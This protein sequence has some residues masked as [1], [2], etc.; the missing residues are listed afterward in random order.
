MNSIPSRSRHELPAGLRNAALAAVLLSSVVGFQA[1]LEAASL[2]NLEALREARPTPGSAL[3][4]S[5]ELR[6][7]IS[8]AESAAQV[9]ALEP[10]ASSRAFV[11]AALSVACGL[12]FVSAG[13]L[14]RPAGLPR[15]GMRGLLGG[16]ALAAAVLRTI[17]G[18]QAALVARR[19]A[20]ALVE[21]LQKNGDFGQLASIERAPA[22]ISTV[23]LT[24]AVAPTALVAGAFV[25]LS[26]YFHSERVKQ[27][28]AF[29]DKQLN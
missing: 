18:A 11:L 15:N 24:V 9:S 29:G 16:S 28:V 20:S 3:V 5:P 13:R 12:V 26:T 2:T 7:K 19:M 8:A 1:M 23:Y 14:L 27:I 4:S 22:V 21:V 10:M 6:E 25:V 17:D